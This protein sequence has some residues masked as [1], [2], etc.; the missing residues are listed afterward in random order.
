[1]RTEFALIHSLWLSKSKV[2][3]QMMCPLHTC[4]APGA[5]NVKIAGKSLLI[6]LI[7]AEHLVSALG[8][9]AVKEKTA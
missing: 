5:V 4:T 9:L 6:S 3:S 7:V 8:L 2:D 1:M